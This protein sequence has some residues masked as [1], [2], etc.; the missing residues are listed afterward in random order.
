MSGEV[1]QEHLWDVLD[2]Y[3]KQNGLVKQQLD[4]YNKFTTDIE[5][6]IKEYGNFTIKVE[7][8]FRVG[9]DFHDEE[10]WDFKFSEELYKTTTNHTEPDNKI[11]K[12]NP[13]MCRLRDLNYESLVKID[14]QYSRYFVNTKLGE[15]KLKD[16]RQIPKIQLA[17]I[18]VMVRSSWC[19]LNQTDKEEKIQ[20]GECEMDQG[21]YF[22]VRGS[23]KV[24]VGQERMAYNFVYTFKTKIESEPWIT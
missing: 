7:P 10:R 2:K 18:P 3:F 4:S 22:I 19:R 11:V 13:M 15:D 21:G 16:K 5:Q 6:V 14:L 20:L 1:Q 12:V 8:Q 24:V 9:E 17:D 23:E